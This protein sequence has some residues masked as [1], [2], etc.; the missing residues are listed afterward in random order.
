MAR[1]ITGRD[2]VQ[3]DCGFLFGRHGS[4]AGYGEL[5]EIDVDTRE[6]KLESRTESLHSTNCSELSLECR[7]SRGGLLPSAP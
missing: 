1:K 6:R 4:R 5:G 7:E 3:P 2:D